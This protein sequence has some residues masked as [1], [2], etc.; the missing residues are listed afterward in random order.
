MTQGTCWPPWRPEMI[1]MSSTHLEP[2]EGILRDHVPDCEVRA[3]GSR[4]AGQPKPWS[5]LDLV[6]IGGQ[7]LDE[8]RRLGLLIEAFQEYSVAKCVLKAW[9]VIETSPSFQASHHRTIRGLPGWIKDRSSLMVSST[10]PNVSP[11]LSAAATIRRQLRAGEFI[12]SPTRWE[13][14]D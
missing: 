12:P 13:R 14:T 10:I 7:P 3:F 5:D 9:T 1:E 11:N 2:V 8:F 4:V 6:V